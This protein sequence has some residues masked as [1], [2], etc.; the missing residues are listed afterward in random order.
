MSR[1]RVGDGRSVLHWRRE[2]LT[3]AGV[4][5][6]SLSSMGMKKREIVVEDKGGEEGWVEEGKIMKDD[7]DGIEE[8]EEEGSKVDGGESSGSRQGQHEDKNRACLRTEQTEEMDERTREDPL[9]TTEKHRYVYA[10]W[11]LLLY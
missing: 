3:T 1:R 5:L 2:L 4:R 7:E 11:I 9:A 10:K 6:E 8:N